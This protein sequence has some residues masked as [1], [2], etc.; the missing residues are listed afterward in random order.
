MPINT[1]NSTAVNASWKAGAAKP[2]QANKSAPTVKQAQPLLSSTSTT[3]DALIDKSPIKTPLTREEALSKSFDRLGIDDNRKTLSKL[4]QGD[5]SSVLIKKESGKPVLD[6]GA[7]VSNKKTNPYGDF[8]WINPKGLKKYQTG[9]VAEVQFQNK[10][11]LK[12]LSGEY[13]KCPLPDFMI[14]L[15]A[16][17][18]CHDTRLHKTNS[19][20]FS[21]IPPAGKDLNGFI[22]R[23]NAPYIGSGLQE[24]YNHHQTDLTT[25]KEGITLC[26][27]AIHPSINSAFINEMTGDHAQT[28]GRPT[29]RKELEISQQEMTKNSGAR[30]LASILDLKAEDLPALRALRDQT[31]SHLKDAY[32][33]DDSKDNTRMFFHFPVALKTA[34]LHLHTWVNKGDHPLN[35][36]RAFDLDDVIHHLES[37]KDIESMILERNNGTFH[38]PVSDSIK[39]IDGMPTK[40][41]VENKANLNL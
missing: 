24:V 17:E 4:H 22:V 35:D 12:H 3:V 13:H 9:S 6:H 34:T 21:Y 1:V 11:Q 20:L 27:Y 18:D 33:V 16:N 39:D 31:V 36:G 32:K 30:S 19:N 7:F 10:E 37:G 23:P 38:L 8:D 15:L 25:N 5:E 2:T 41:V 29:T 28:K 26:T 14:Q 40:G